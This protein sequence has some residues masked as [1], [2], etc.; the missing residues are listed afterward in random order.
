VFAQG[1]N[2]FCPY[3]QNP[4]L[5][6]PFGELLPE[7]GVLAFLRSRAKLLDGVVISGGEPAIIEDLPEFIKQIKG[8]G[9]KVKL[10]TN[11]SRP[12]AVVS[13]IEKKLVDYV[14]LDLKADP[15][16]YPKELGPPEET[17]KVLETLSALKRLGKPHEFRTTAASPFINDDSV[18]ALAKAAAG[19]AP[20]FL[21]KLSLKNVLNPSFMEK[22]PS[23]PGDEDLLRFRDIARRF[24]PCHIR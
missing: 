22:H 19:E 8:M 17:A 3:C 18:R 23:Q 5:A 7:E 12:D 4:D 14:A 13:L 15:E 24:L 9:F 10:D 6:R 21:Q 2:F 1:C 11:G 16:N 20:L